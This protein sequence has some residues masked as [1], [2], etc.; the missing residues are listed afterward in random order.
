MSIVC[1]HG[2]SSLWTAGLHDLSAHDSNLHK[3][4][5]TAIPRSHRLRFQPENHPSV[6]TN[7]GEDQATQQ[8][9]RG[10]ICVCDTKSQWVSRYLK[11]LVVLQRCFWDHA[12]AKQY[13]VGYVLACTRLSTPQATA[14]RSEL[15]SA[16]GV[17]NM[18]DL[19]GKRPPSTNRC[20][21]R[22]YSSLHGTCIAELRLLISDSA[23]GGPCTVSRYAC[24]VDPSVKRLWQ[25]PSTRHSFAM[26]SLPEARVPKLDMQPLV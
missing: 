17:G 15:K 24:V 20:Q 25:H 10:V 18:S 6:A 5:S 14:P 13:C 16:T 2:M 8:H 3:A 11:T 22:L 26:P 1:V 4:G 12:H 7:V 23:A 9:S 19:P 21:F